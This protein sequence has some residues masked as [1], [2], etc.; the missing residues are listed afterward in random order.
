MQGVDV[1]ARD[2]WDS[3]ALF[4]ASLCGH[5]D[6]VRLLLSRGAR[7][8][9]KTFD[10]ERILYAALNSET[11]RLLLEEGFRYAAAR[12][13][14]HFCDYIENLYD[15]EDTAKDVAFAL[16]GAS[17]AA[18]R[19]V[20][21]ARCPSLAARWSGQTSPVELG[22]ARVSAVALGALLR[23]CYTE[24]LEL[25][26]DCAAEAQALCR[27]CRLP[28]LA[29]DLERESA[30]LRASGQEGH[31]SAAAAERLVC[32]PPPAEA[33]RRL[34]DDFGR[35][36]R[37][38]LDGGESPPC[39]GPAGE[40][41]AF[42]VDG[43]RYDVHACFLRGR[44]EFL[45]AAMD[46]QRR[47]GLED[48]APAGPA[49][50]CAL[51]DM[52]AATWEGVLAWAYTDRVDAALS[53]DG[54]VDL[55]AAADRLLLPP[56]KARVALLAHP[57]LGPATALPLLALGERLRCEKL[58]AMATRCVAQHLE[59]LAADPLLA[60]LAA[61]SASGVRQRHAF[62]S[63]PVLDELRDSVAA[64][65][66]DGELS[67]GEEGEEDGWGLFGGGSGHVA[68]GRRQ[69]EGAEA[70]DARLGR[71]AASSSERRRKLALLEAL[72]LAVDASS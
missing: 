25:P 62:D 16:R 27:Q 57:F 15:N 3:P 50:A 63:V 67:D 70:R 71:W 11:K 45:A 13:H 8:E 37:T 48:V 17:L 1:M 31:P 12:S 6:M 10:G 53:L 61:D 38:V 34:Q 60:E 26:S 55:L 51:T 28:A 40:T 69:D 4:Y 2:A 41:T 68:R 21:H 72:Q 7:C 52:S 5:I 20:L 54:L 14:D 44:S 47:H 56:L 66:G 30:R 23:W 49:P 58:A 59:A 64:L 42:V 22:G 35:L 19:A 65:H 43:R 9:E 46:W 32:E 33:K 18:H 29:A 39:A 24:R 36:L